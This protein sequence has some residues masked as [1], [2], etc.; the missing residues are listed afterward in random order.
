MTHPGIIALLGAYVLSQFYRAFLAVLAPVLERDLGAGAD[1]LALASGLWF[2]TFAAMQIPVGEALDRIG[3]RRS[4]ATLFLMGGAGGAAVFALATAPWHITLAMILIGIGCSPVM[5]ASYFIFARSFPSAAFATL[6]AMVIGIGSLGNLASAA[7][8]AWAEAA[9]GWR[10]TLWVLA[11]VTAAIA[12]AVWRLVDDPPPA[13]RD[14]QGSVIDLLKIPAL[15]LIFPLMAVQYAPSMGLRGLWAGPYSADV[16]GADPAMIGTVTLVMG[17]VMVVGNFGYGPMDRLLRTRK[18]VAFGGNLGG[19]L[20][21]LALWAFWDH[22]L[23]LSTV[24]LSLIGLFGAS[25]AVLIAHAKA[26]FP[27]HLTGRGV[28]LMNLFG[29]GGVG[30]GQIATRQIHASHGGTPEAFPA[31]F[32][33]FGVTLLIGLALYLFTEDRLD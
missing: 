26:L 3:P 15:W 23:W 13:P 25:F 2:L 22:S 4:A 7:P 9:I 17:L 28:T 1:D 18:W 20:A 24:L 19:A 14:A 5:M 27:P 33:Y 16:F 32:L 31:I 6:G 29:V 8:M 11:A 12:L 30:L 10:A 21:C